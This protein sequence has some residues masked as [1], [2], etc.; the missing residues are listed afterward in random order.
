[1]LRTPVATIGALSKCG[2]EVGRWFKTPIDPMPEDPEAVFFASAACLNSARKG[3]FVINLPMH[4]AMSKQ[5]VD[6]LLDTVQ[7]HGGPPLSVAEV[8][9]D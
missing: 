2:F 7:K 1:M 8:V 9:A 3:S 4:L 6:T 5:D